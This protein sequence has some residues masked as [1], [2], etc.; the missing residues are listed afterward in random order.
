M[1][2]HYSIILYIMKQRGNKPDQVNYN[3]LFFTKLSYFG[4]LIHFFISNGLLLLIF[5]AN[6]IYGQ[7]N[8]INIL[9]YLLLFLFNNKHD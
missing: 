5:K 1:F 6:Q 7:I 4:Y 9:Y 2:F 3:N 8:T